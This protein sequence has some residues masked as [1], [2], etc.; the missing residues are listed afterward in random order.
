MSRVGPTARI[1]LLGQFDLRLDG[2]AVAPLESGRAETLLAYLLLHRDAAQPR[3]RVAF[4]LWPD[5]TEA[6]ART[7]LRHVLH[8]LRGRLPDAGRYLEIT[9][10]TLRWRSDEPCWLDVDAFERL[11]ATDASTGS[12]GRRAAL[13]EAVA[14]YTGDLLE[15]RYG[16]RRT[17]PVAAAVPGRA[18][19][20]GGPVRGRR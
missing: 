2:E 19:R 9:P 1:R 15:G 3:Q 16:V 18:R 13:R 5:S 14:L 10:R 8:T 11:L 17:G 20:A 6:Q 12:D 7:N 4:Q